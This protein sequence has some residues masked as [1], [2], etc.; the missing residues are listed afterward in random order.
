M[1]YGGKNYKRIGKDNGEFKIT[2][3]GVWFLDLRLNS[4]KR[5]VN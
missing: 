2:R 1:P 4:N 3:G 5:I